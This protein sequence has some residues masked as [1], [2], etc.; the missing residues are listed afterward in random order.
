MVSTLVMV[1]L[2]NHPLVMV[3]L[4]N[5]PLVMVSLSNHTLSLSKE[6]KSVISCPPSVYSL[7]EVYA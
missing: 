2:S 7:P 5:H 1:S 4:S 3:S 6:D